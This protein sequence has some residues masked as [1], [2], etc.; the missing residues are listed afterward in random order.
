[1][2]VQPY[3]LPD[4]I[5]HYEAV[6]VVEVPAFLTVKSRQYGCHMNIDERSDERLQADLN[7]ES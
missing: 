4:T 1:M 2:H 3:V 5:A 6:M 7:L